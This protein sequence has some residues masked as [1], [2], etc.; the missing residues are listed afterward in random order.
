MADAAV[1]ST[2]SIP[3]A[4]PLLRE[5]SLYLPSFV[6]PGV[7]SFIS[8]VVLGRVLGVALYGDYALAA[9]VVSVAGGL[10][11]EWL[12]QTTLRFSGEQ[13]EGR[14]SLVALTSNTIVLLL[15][16]CGGGVVILVLGLVPTGHG[17]MASAA[18]L[19]V[20]GTIA[21]KALF[22][23]LRLMHGAGPYTSA[24]LVAATLGPGVGLAL[25]VARPQPQWFFVGQSIGVGASLA[26]AWRLCG[27]RPATVSVRT[28]EIDRA[29]LREM[30]AYGVPIAV[31]A[32]GGYALSVL[33]RF[34][35]A[36]LA[37]SA[38]LGRYAASYQLADK[39][40]ALLF[41]PL[42]F[43]LHPALIRSWL[44][45]E[46]HDV[47]TSLEGAAR[48]LATIGPPL[49]L[50]LALLGDPLLRVL[51]GAGFGGQRW[52]ILNIAGGAL[53]WNLGT[54][55]H[56]PLELDKRT[57]TITVMVLSSAAVNA[58][59]NVVL[60]PAYGALGASIATLLTY[61]GYC[62]LAAAVARRA[63]LVQWAIPWRTLVR[64]SVLAT[65]CAALIIESAHLRTV[66]P[67]RAL[68]WTGSAMFALAILRSCIG[69]LARELTR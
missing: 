46:L 9:S 27:P 66:G 32:I 52:V 24:S 51:V 19:V 29:V 17:A 22:A 68:L 35:I 39:S 49:V 63:G 37:N 67:L 41:A 13:I 42:L 7:T 58:L 6:V 64:S 47:R 4:R 33:D 62:A 28:L 61:V 69:V 30:L 23:R 26:L 8:L 44:R 10:F 15:A 60:I 16:S 43:A 54:L 12:G 3:Q 59:L 1:V 38:E 21:S 5:V 65:A 55:L 18:A 53:L 2:R 56:L 57:T 11:G 25:V 31:T 50:L 20:V 14:L 36:A 34:M 48:V 40:V 45:A